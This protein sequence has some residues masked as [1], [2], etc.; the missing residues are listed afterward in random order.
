MGISNGV[1]VGCNEGIPGE[2]DGFTEGASLLMTVGRREGFEEGEV[3]G[4]S[5]ALIV[6]S[7][8]G[9]HDGR[10]E[11]FAVGELE[12]PSLRMTVGPRDGFEE[13][14]VV[15]RSLAVIGHSL[16]P[17]NT[18]SRSASPL[19]VLSLTSDVQMESLI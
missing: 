17:P 3:V 4:T 12:G 1:A 14:E 19:N 13:G 6:G 2:L 8:D 18:R 15:G 9:F 11:G 5:L 10:N 16:L 7:D